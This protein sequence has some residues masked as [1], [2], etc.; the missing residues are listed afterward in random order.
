MYQSLPGGDFIDRNQ[1]EQQ[2][3]LQ[4]DKD[5]P[6]LVDRLGGIGLIGSDAWLT[7]DSWLRGRLSST[8]LFPLAGVRFAL[9]A[10]TD[11]AGSV[12]QKVKNNEQLT[13]AA[14]Y[15]GLA[16][17]IFGPKTRVVVSGGGLEAL[18]KLM[19]EIDGTLDL[20]ETGLSADANDLEIVVDNVWQVTLDLVC[21]KLQAN[22]LQS[23]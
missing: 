10:L 13:V 9:C 19:P 7:Q 8:A 14:T 4:R 23:T 21:Q 15:P 18:P 1:N 17:R 20:V 5:I 16:K 11:K 6:T 12:R 2:V 22:L 3:I